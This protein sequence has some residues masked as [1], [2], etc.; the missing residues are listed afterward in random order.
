MKRPR[1]DRGSFVSMPPPAFG[2][3]EETK[4]VPQRRWWDSMAFLLRKKDRCNQFLNWLPQ[5]A[6][7]I[8][9]L[10]GF[11]SHGS[12]NRY[13]RRWYLFFGAGGGT[14]TH[15][16]SLPKDFESSSSTIP[17]HRRMNI[18]KDVIWVSE[19]AQTGGSIDLYRIAHLGQKCKEKVLRKDLL[20][21]FRKCLDFLGASLHNR[22]WLHNTFRHQGE[23]GKD[24]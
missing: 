21:L 5:N 14:R 10:D 22:C 3:F 7:G 4:S 24:T 13:H 23:W 1:L 20:V 19:A 6:T 18:R 16:V 15:T 17:T 12:K 8:L 11:E 9:H 2:A